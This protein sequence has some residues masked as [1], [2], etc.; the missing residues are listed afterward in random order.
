VK[1]VAAASPMVGGTPMLQEES[2]ITNRQD[3]QEFEPIDEVY[4]TASVR[5][6]LLHVL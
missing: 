2:D 5:F 3:T 1:G 6:W 4:V